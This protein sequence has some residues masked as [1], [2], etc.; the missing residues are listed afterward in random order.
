[1]PGIVP[2]ANGPGGRPPADRRSAWRELGPADLP[3]LAYLARRCLAA[4]GG[5][6]FA[7]D[8]AFLRSSYL[9]GGP[10]IGLFDGPELLSASAM[11]WTQPVSADPGVVICGMVDP[12]WR[13]RGIGA[14]GLDWA[15]DQASQARVVLA[16]SE[17]LTD[18]AHALYLSRNMTQILAEHVLQLPAD[19]P[20]PP[21][22]APEGM[23][24]TEWGD[25][26][27]EPK[28]PEGE[29]E[30]A[31]PGRFFA[32]Y[33]AAFAERPGFPGRSAG[34]WISWISDDDDFMPQWTLL[35]SLPDASGGPGDVG[36]IA[37][38]ATGWIAQ[39]GV[40]PDARGRAVG[41][42]LIAEVIRRMRAA[43]E[44][45]VTLNVAVDNARADA[46]Y[47]RLGF[48]RI[49]GRARYRLEVGPTGEQ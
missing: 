39:V 44:S 47:R 38:E 31:D 21:V 3:A 7:A 26:H 16:E 24:L 11:R 1:M 36:F 37:G 20:V 35:A 34:E 17:A 33:A 12:A 5:Q 40:I 15:L 29:R 43:G 48:V 13:R 10:A 28:A 2:D 30:Y 42:S 6:P 32:V 27:R 23:R 41:A 22:A 18:G 45:T 8:P 4:D 9:A 14:Q 49:G 25:T 46:L 19:A